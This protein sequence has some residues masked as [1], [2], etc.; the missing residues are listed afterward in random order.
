MWI[1]KLV[2]V[3]FETLWMWQEMQ[4]ISCLEGK[5]TEL[6]G[7]NLHSFYTNLKCSH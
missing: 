6:I 7:K 3:G 4:N 5:S 2:N 1:I